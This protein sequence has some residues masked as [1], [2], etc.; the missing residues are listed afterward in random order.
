MQIDAV[1]E[2]EAGDPQIAIDFLV[3]N[4]NLSKTRL[5]DLMNKGGVWRVD[6]HDHRERLRRA[7]TDIFV[8]DQIEIFYDEALLS[9][10]PLKAELLHDAGQYSVWSKPNG[11]PLTGTDWGDFNSF[12]RAIELATHGEREFYWLTP[13]DYE[14][15]GVQV[16][17]HSRKAAA[18]L[19]EIFDPEGL[20]SANITYRCEVA[21]DFTAESDG[22][23]S[24]DE[25]SARTRFKKIRFDAQPN[26]SVVEAQLE[27]G[28][29]C[30]VRRQL[31]ALG[32]PVVGDEA[33]GRASEAEGLLKLK[34]VE[35][36]FTCP[37]TQETLVFN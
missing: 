33:Y 36:R 35:V 1:L 18:Q 4:I 24:L 27:T 13:F 3:D 11:M 16:I 21:G 23:V 17:A 15:S 2:V 28:R 22:T 34:C 29:K 5:K 9:L 20:T 10:K 7:M 30:Q 32:F 12:E 8:G 6:Q 31:A 26:R 19:A 37:L 25:A 14:A